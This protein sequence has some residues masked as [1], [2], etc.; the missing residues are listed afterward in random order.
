MSIR[1][2]NAFG[3]KDVGCWLYKEIYPPWTPMLGFWVS[4]FLGCRWGS[5]PDGY[6]PKVEEV[7]ISWSM[8]REG[9]GGILLEYRL[10]KMSDA[11]AVWKETI[12]R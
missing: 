2:G 12:R 6:K 10:I 11:L 4:M 9:M 5:P 1:P 3:G 8:L 7:S